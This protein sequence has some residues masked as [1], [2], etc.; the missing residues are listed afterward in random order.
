MAVLCSTWQRC[1]PGSQWLC[2]P[3]AASGLTP[4]TAAL[5]GATRIVGVDIQSDKLE[6]DSKFGATDVVDSS[7]VDVVEAIDQLTGS[8]GV[9]H[10][11]V[12]AGVSAVT[13]AA[14]RVL[15]FDGTAYLVGAAD[16]GA[17]LPLRISP[18]ETPVL[19][20]QKGIRGSRLGSSNFYHDIPMYVDLYLTGRLNLDDLVS[21]TIA[22]DEINN[23]CEA[24]ERGSIARSVIIFP[25]PDPD[26]P[27]STPSNVKETRMNAVNTLEL[28]KAVAAKVLPEPSLYI[29]GTAGQY[30]GDTPIAVA[31]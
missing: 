4:Q 12:M 29:G 16:T 9:D 19:P 1:N 25:P 17:E 28:H 23:A 10:A 14:M 31:V 7:Q 8:K 2:S 11:F 24:L 22:L 21:Q 15:G 3:A 13:E 5:A 30:Y 27:D 18:D 26:S 6:L 20:Y